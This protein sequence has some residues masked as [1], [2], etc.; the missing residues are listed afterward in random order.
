M[1]GNMIYM[2]IFNIMES[3]VTVLNMKRGYFRFQNAPKFHN[4]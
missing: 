2:T 1:C 3:F 4:I